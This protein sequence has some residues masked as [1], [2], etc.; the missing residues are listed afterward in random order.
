MAEV[1][2]GFVDENNV[3]ESFYVVEE[4]DIETLNRIKQMVG[5][6]RCHLIDMSIEPA[7]IG[8]TYWNGTR[9]VFPSPYPSWV[10]NDE[11][12]V[13]QSPIPYPTP[14]G[15]EDDDNKKYYVWDESTVSWKEQTLE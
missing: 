9:F 1:T 13:W 15:S 14:A 6:N 10:W 8:S 11:N 7:A 2:Y 12:Y 3:L 4:D 5:H